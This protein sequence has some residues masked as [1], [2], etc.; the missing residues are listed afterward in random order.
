MAARKKTRTLKLYELHVEPEG[1]QPRIWRKI[2]VPGS[3][4]LPKLHDL[5][6]LVMGLTDSHL[7]SFQFGQN[8]YSAGYP[9][10]GELDELGMLDE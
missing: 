1:I 6:Q 9:E 8:I 2:L 3:I 5:L 7:H 4:K 10:L